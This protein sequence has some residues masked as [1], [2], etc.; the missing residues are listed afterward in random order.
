MPLI[1]NFSL[2]E[3][4]KTIADKTY[5]KPSAYKSMFIQKTYKALGGTFTDDHK[6]RNL[7]R[8]KKEKWSDIGGRD[9]PVYRPHKRISRKTPLTVDEIDPINAKRQIALKQIIKGKENLPPFVAKGKEDDVY[10]VSDYT[11]KQAK[12]LGVQVFP[13]DKPKYKIKIYDKNGIFMFYGG[14]SQYSDFPSYMQS[15]GKE[16]AD[17]RREL[18][19]IRHRKEIENEGSRG[20]WIAQ[21]LW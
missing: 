4:A 11:K 17:S 7:T 12:K 2:Y 16:Y 18:F 8:W 15:H 5:S 20:W 3:K 14:N 9:Y 21:L 1:N 19:R 13:S 10:K 6:P